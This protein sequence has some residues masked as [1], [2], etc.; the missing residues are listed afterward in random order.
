MGD[1]LDGSEQALMN[2]EMGPV[3]EAFMQVRSVLGSWG[4]TMRG[5]VRNK[6]RGEKAPY[7]YPRSQY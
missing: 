2:F 4:K 5:V 6:K 7:A 1:A 3:H